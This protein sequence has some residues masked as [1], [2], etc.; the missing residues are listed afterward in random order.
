VTNSANF[1]IPSSGAWCETGT[2][3]ESVIALLA[4]GR[5]PQAAIELLDQQ[6]GL[7]VI[8]VLTGKV[9]W[10]RNA[11]RPTPRGAGSLPR[12]D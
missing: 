4:Y 12:V 11:Q 6:Q 3:R 7:Q 8:N 1:A 10:M 5:K 2:I 9:R